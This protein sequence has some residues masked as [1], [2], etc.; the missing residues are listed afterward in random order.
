MTLI[1]IAQA[2]IGT[3]Q[4]LANTVVISGNRNV[5]TKAETNGSQLAQAQTQSFDNPKYVIQ[6]IKITNTS[7]T[8]TYNDILKL[9][10]EKYDGTNPIILKI[11]YGS[12][13]VV[14][15]LSESTTGISVVLDDYNIT[16]DTKDSK[17]AYIPEMSLTFTETR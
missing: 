1:T 7:G 2:T 10:K 15:A 5:I 12:G 17:D 3:V 9:Y 8:L 4:V 14:P 11:V 6:G 16:Y 13:L